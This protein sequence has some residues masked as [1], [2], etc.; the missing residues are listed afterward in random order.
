MGTVDTHRLRVMGALLLMALALAPVA[1]ACD[2]IDPIDLI[3]GDGVCAGVLL[4]GDAA[5]AYTY[6]EL[7]EIINGEAG[8]YD[9]YGFVAAAFQN[10]G[11]DV[12]GGQAAATLSLFNQGTAGVAAA[13]Y[14]DPQS[15]TG[16]PIVDWSGS[17]EARL[18]V[19]FGVTTLQFREECFFGQVVVISAEEAAETAARCLA[20]VIAASIRGEVPTD[21]R[22]WG[23]LKVKF[24]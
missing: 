7:T 17:G 12:G 11:V 20:D 14:A 23:R 18:R 3:P 16:D 10:Y 19:A 5:G 15:G 8:L 2:Q 9:L 1:R 13:L 4:D 21:G 6:A 22:S 24:E